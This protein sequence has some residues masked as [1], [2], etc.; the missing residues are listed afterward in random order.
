MGLTDHQRTKGDAGRTHKF[1]N[2]E[3]HDS[4]VEGGVANEECSSSGLPCEEIFLT[5]WNLAWFLIGL[6]C[7][8]F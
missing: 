2:V 6:V 8:L 5:L 3:D 1:S 7:I 4:K